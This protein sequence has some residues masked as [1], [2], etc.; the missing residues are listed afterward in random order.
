MQIIIYFQHTV[1]DSILGINNLQT[2]SNWEEMMAVTNLKTTPLT[3]GPIISMAQAGESDLLLASD[4]AIFKFVPSTEDLK[5]LIQRGNIVDMTVTDPQHF[6]FVERGVLVYSEVFKCDKETGECVAYFATDKFCTG[7]T[8]M[9]GYYVMTFSTFTEGYVKIVDETGKTIKKI[10]KDAVGENLFTKKLSRIFVSSDYDMFIADRG[11]NSL[12]VFKLHLVK[13]TATLQSELQLHVNSF[14]YHDKRLLIAVG[15]KKNEVVE[16]T[17]IGPKKIVE[18]KLLVGEP[19]SVCVVGKYL[20]VA[21]RK[22][23]GIF[24]RD[25]HF[26]QVF[27]I[28]Q[29]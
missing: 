2:D 29:Q 18:S 4:V 19:M 3:S 11:A 5:K 24:T 26:I 17:P 6:A 14:C 15:G 8:Y 1:V 27:E 21:V 28:S 10:Q 9:D 16:M 13:D 12:Q 22:D 7:L 23:N 25:E 20:F